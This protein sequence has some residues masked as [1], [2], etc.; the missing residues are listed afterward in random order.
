MFLNT[1]HLLTNMYGM[2]IKKF[3]FYTEKDIT[4]QKIFLQ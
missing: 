1:K 4:E 3:P 2:N